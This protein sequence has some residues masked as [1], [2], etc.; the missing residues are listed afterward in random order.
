M[1]VLEKFIKKRFQVGTAITKE[2]LPPPHSD[3]STSAGADGIVCLPQPAGRYFNVDVTVPNPLPLPTAS[4]LFAPMK[5]SKPLT[6]R[7]TKTK[8]PG[9]M[10]SPPLTSL[11]S[12]HGETSRSTWRPLVDSAFP[13]VCTTSIEDITPSKQLVI[14]F[15]ALMSVRG[16][17]VSCQWEAL[18][19]SQS[20]CSV[21]FN[22]PS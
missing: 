3:T 13:P 17:V 9:T 14:Y 5:W 8:Q 19:T 1:R 7:E 20:D 12:S 6:P 16:R 4:R 2:P 11:S 21:S 10:R 15:F 22:L 18:G